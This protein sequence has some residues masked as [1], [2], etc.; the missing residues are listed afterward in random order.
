MDQGRRRFLLGIGLGALALGVPEPWWMK[1]FQPK[2]RSMIAVP[3]N[4]GE[5]V[6]FGLTSRED[7]LD[8]IT[9]ISPVDTPLFTLLRQSKTSPVLHEWVTD[10]LEGIV[11]GKNVV[12]FMP[13]ARL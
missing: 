7:L 5:V 9:M 8:V 2:G 10:E 6:P 13:R 3:A 12:R 1:L 4:Y 11:P